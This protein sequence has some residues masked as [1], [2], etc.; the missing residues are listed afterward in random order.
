MLTL[1][2]REGETL[3]IGPD[4]AIVV[5]EV[6]GGQVKLGF[7]APR[8]VRIGRP[9]VFGDTEA[10]IAARGAFIRK[11]RGGSGDD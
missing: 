3:S 7:V 2:R 5:I 8:E 6:R 4:V 9:E 10:T 11:K 1:S